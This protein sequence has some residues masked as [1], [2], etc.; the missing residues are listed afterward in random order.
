VVTKSVTAV[1]PS[2]EGLKQNIQLN[3]DDSTIE[4]EQPES[5]LRD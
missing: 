5:R 2:I 3:V 1:F 4:S